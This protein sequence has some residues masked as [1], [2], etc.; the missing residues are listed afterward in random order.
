MRADDVR[1]LS[2]R[3]MWILVRMIKGRTTEE[4][5]RRVPRVYS[6]PGSTTEENLFNVVWSSMLING[7]ESDFWWAEMRTTLHRR[8]PHLRTPHLTSADKQHPSRRFVTH[9]T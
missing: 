2:P 9:R 7:T 1:L 3:R 5:I 8:R 6:V 4:F